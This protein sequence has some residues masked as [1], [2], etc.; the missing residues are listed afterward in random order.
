MLPWV[1]GNLFLARY[2]FVQNELVHLLAEH[3]TPVNKVNNLNV[4]YLK[5][6]KTHRGPHNMPSKGNCGQRAACLRPCHRHCLATIAF[7]P[8]IYLLRLSL[9]CDGLITIMWRV[10]VF[11]N[12]FTLTCRRKKNSLCQVITES[13]I[14]F[15]EVEAITVGYLPVL[16]NWKVDLNLLGDLQSLHIFL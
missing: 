11:I 12:D 15:V 16:K 2:T 8:Y 6:L 9:H 14:T 7:F 1:I 13:G 3:L 4:N 5:I 10:N